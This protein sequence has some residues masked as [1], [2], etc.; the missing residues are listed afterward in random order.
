MYK[1]SLKFLLL[2]FMR[3]ITLN[4]NIANILS[5]DRE[6]TKKKEKKIRVFKIYFF[7]F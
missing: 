3:I 7:Y 5:N 6:L 1:F 2:L 4:Q